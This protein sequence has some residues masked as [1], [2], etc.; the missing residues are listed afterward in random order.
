MNKE[1]SQVS[2]HADCTPKSLQLFYVK[3]LSIWK[4]NNSLNQTFE[5]NFN[6]F[7]VYVS[8]FFPLENFRLRD[9][10]LLFSEGIK[11]KHECGMG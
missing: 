6:P 2:S 4:P 11:M 10:F 1:K 5:R 9:I 3:T 8:L 7:H